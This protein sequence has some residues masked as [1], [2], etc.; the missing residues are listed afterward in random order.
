M[1]PVLTLSGSAHQRGQHYGAAAAPL[2]RHSI[3]SYARLFAY[4][5]GIDWQTS[6]A[7]ALEFL[8]LLADYCPELL[9]EMQGIA[10]GAGLHLG[11][12]VALNVR[13]ELLA[14]IGAGVK[15]PDAAAAMS[16]NRAAGVPQHADEPPPSLPATSAPDD[17]ECTTLVALP[18][19]SAGGVPWLAQTWDWNGDQRA[20]CLLLRIHAPGQPA[21]LT[22]TEGGILAKIGLNSAGVAV[23]LN[24][25]RSRADGQ[26]PGMPVHVLLRAMLQTRSLAE[27]QALAERLPAGGSSCVTV[28]EAAGQAVSLELTPGGVGV[29][30]PSNGLLAHTNHCLDAET[31]EG[32]KPLDPASSTRQRL[33]RADELLAAAHGQVDA[34]TLKAIL[35]DRHDAPFC[36][37]R[38]PDLGLPPVDRAESVCAVL[39]DMQ[40][41]VMHVA[42]GVPCEVE[43]EEV[44]L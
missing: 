27:A 43:F 33:S 15:H 26:T 25:L 5:R 9:E 6:Q 24:L 23:S 17:G 31:I 20:A 35:R 39:M 32:E 29:L 19:A 30:H 44:Y 7:L 40:R 11:E 2:I 34:A 16:R 42:P 4:R 12:I 22:L 1:F 13:T 21:V 37:C 14:G 38:T 41:Q 28:L 8:P 18:E 10:D 36:I 3:A